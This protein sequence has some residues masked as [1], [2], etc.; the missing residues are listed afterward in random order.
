MAREAKSLTKIHTTNSCRTGIG[1]Q[2]FLTPK[3]KLFLLCIMLSL[4]KG[5]TYFSS[6]RVN[7]KSCILCLTSKQYLLCTR[8]QRQSSFSHRAPRVDGVRKESP[9]LLRWKRIMTALRAQTW[10]P[11]VGSWAIKDFLWVTPRHW[12]GDSAGMPPDGDRTELKT[13]RRGMASHNQGPVRSP[14]S[15]KL[16]IHAREARNQAVEAAEPCPTGPSCCAKRCGLLCSAGTEKLLTIIKADL[17]FRMST[18]KAKDETGGS[19]SSPGSKWCISDP[20]QGQRMKSRR[21]LGR[22]AKNVHS[23]S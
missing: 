21:W 2:G 23:G 7:K 18:W 12:P 14:A 1:A 3:L 5:N 13:A 16:R 22:R 17:S 6:G 15:A 4:K 10:P 8:D 19:C 9:V 20:G 11:G